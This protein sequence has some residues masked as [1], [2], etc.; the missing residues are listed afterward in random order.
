MPIF[1]YDTSVIISRKP[2]VLPVKFGNS[3]W[4]AVVLLELMA[5]AQDESQRK[6][7]E[8]LF[9]KYDENE[10]LMVP[11]EDD[12]LLAGKVL[13]LLTQDRKRAH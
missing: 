8:H 4:S 3:L 11:N 5:S 10:C 6:I 2:T 12:W 7:Y 13:Y 9:H 1:T